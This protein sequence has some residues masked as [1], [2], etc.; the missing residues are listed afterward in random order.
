MGE[1]ARLTGAATRPAEGVVP[2]PVDRLDVGVQ[3]MRTTVR[4][5]VGRA[6]VVGGMTKEPGTDGRQM[7]LVA[8]VAGGE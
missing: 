2:V 7:Y 4:V 3:Q 1:P 6:V 5:P 8:E